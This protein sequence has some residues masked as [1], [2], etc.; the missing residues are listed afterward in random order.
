MKKITTKRRLKKVRDARQ[1][2]EITWMQQHLKPGG[3][4]SPIPD[5]RKLEEEVPHHAE[6]ILCSLK[7]ARKKLGG[8]DM[9]LDYQGK[10]LIELTKYYSEC[11]FTPKRN[12]VCDYFFANSNYSYGDA[13]TCYALMRHLRPKRV[14]EVGSGYSSCVLLDINRLFFGGRIRQTFVEPHPELL[15][16]LVAKGRSVNFSTISNNVQNVSLTVFRQLRANDILFI[17][18]SHV[19]K[20]GSD[21]NRIV[22]DILPSLNAGVWI[23]FHDIFPG[24]EYPLEW[25][26]EGR[27]WNEA[28]L[29][30]AFLQYNASFQIE[31]ST[32]MMGII[33]ETYI[34][35]HMPLFLRNIG[36]GLWIR[37][38][39]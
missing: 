37:K 3:F 36:G 31:L 2:S 13:I 7:T 27:F 1:S 39:H 12:S 19:S 25:T 5:R 35:R 6:N 23:H 11:P 22:F 34:K 28:Y 21:V 15:E 10:L 17:D 8:I 29:L 4:Y 32:T 26:L 14:I 24:F 38:L 16:T 9:R 20:V 30:R 33:H 18:S